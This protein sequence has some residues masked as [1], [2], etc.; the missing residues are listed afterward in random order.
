[1]Y[2]INVQNKN[3]FDIDSLLCRDTFHHFISKTLFIR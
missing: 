1:M 3:I 2:K